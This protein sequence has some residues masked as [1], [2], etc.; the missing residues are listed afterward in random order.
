MNGVGSW[1]MHG[2]L[3]DYYAFRQMFVGMFKRK[4]FHARR[5]GARRF[6]EEDGFYTATFST[7]KQAH[8]FKG[9]PNLWNRLLIKT[10]EITVSTGI[11]FLKNDTKDVLQTIHYRFE[12]DDDERMA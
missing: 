2:F 5:C 9:P 6:S 1:L 10:T 7:K 4:G 8:G 12:C 3:L 11:A